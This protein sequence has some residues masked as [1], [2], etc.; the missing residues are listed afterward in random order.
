MKKIILTAIASQALFIS[1]EKP[2]EVKEQPAVAVSQK[3]ESPDFDMLLKC[4][5]YSYDEKY[6]ITADYGCLYD[7]KGI[8]PY[9]NLIIY[10]VPKN[11]TVLNNQQIEAETQKVNRLNIEQLKE[12]FE[13]FVYLTPKE[14]LNYNEQGDPIYYHNGAYK[15]EVY[16][17][18]Q[19]KWILT[20]SINIRNVAENQKEQKWRES[21]ILSKTKQ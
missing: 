10:L 13:V 18:T 11:K 14:F 16:T 3:K 17:H 19:N 6:F 12:Q 20:D 4:S 21:F 8:N 9:G 7:P 1:C 5:E 15:E 2:K